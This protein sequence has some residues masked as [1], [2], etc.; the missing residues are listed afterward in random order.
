MRK[1]RKKEDTIL[2]ICNF[3]PVVY[4]KYRIGVPYKCEYKEVL[5]SDWEEFGGSNEKNASIIKA[6]A[7][8]WHNQKFSMEI[9][10]P[11]LSA[12]YLKPVNYR[13]DE[14][15]EAEEEYSI[16]LLVP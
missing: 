10:V 8:K 2:I 16:E 13:S 6:E 5:S 7:Y 4:K 9:K 15:A 12:V 14:A 11:P 3:T 1:S